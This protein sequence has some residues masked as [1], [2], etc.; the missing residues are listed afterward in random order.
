VVA[1][2]TPAVFRLPIDVELTTSQGTRTERIEITRRQQQFTF[3]LDGKP[4][5]VVF[6]KGARIL[7]KAE[8]T[9]PGLMSADQLTQVISPAKNVGA[10]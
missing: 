9:Q 3:Q 2:N 4:L 6:D 1:A 5:K 7:M 8:I 10:Y